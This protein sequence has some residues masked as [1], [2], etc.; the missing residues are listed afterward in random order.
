MADADT[1]R[2]IFSSFERYEEFSETQ[3][4]LLQMDLTKEPSKD[5]QV[6]DHT[7]YQKLVN[8]VC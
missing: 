4:A 7:L 1:E 6:E 5:E 3:T 8:T 2:K